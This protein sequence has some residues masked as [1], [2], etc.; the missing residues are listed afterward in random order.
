MEVYQQDVGVEFNCTTTNGCLGR[1]SLPE[2][3]EA[4]TQNQ[5]FILS[6]FMLLSA[7]TNCL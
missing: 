1:V 4:I 2:L 3:N 5:H 6:A 7:K